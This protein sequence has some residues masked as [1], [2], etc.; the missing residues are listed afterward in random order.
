MKNE[1]ITGL[2]IGAAAGYFLAGS[3][4]KQQPPANTL[5][6]NGYFPSLLPGSRPLQPYQNRWSGHGFSETSYQANQVV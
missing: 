1:L 5:S 2:I 6:V 3:I 4:N